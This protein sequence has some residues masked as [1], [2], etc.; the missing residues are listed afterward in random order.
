M[1]GEP[2]GCFGVFIISSSTLDSIGDCYEFGILLLPLLDLGSF[3]VDFL[4]SR[5]FDFE[6]DYDLSLVNDFYEFLLY[7]ATT[8]LFLLVSS[9]G[10][11]TPKLS[12]GV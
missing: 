12:K 8:L 6:L 7:V 2:T 5:D 9:G 10:C 4:L 11:L 1:E 3:E